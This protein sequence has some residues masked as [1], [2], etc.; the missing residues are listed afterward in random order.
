MKRLSFFVLKTAII[1]LGAVVFLWMLWFPQTEGRAVGLDLISIYAD[2]FILYAYAAST[3]FFAALYQMYRVL[4]LLGAAKHSSK[5]ISARLKTIQ[6]CAIAL[7]I[8]VTLPLLYL[9]AFLRG[10]DDIIGGVVGG[11]IMI[12]ISAIIWLGSKFA[13]VKLQRSSWVKQA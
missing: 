13:Q 10:E 7:A 5:D 6:Y 9:I 3:T 4:S 11:L 1:I 2:P 12:G 8:L